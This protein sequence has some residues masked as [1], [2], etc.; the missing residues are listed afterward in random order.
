MFWAHT[1][2]AIVWF[3]VPATLIVSWLIA[4]LLAPV[5]PDHLPG[6]GPFRLHDYRGL[7]THRFTKFGTVLC[8]AFG[9]WTHIVLDAFTHN[10]TWFALHV[11]LYTRPLGPWRFRDQAWTL[12]RIGSLGCHFGLS[13]LSLFLLFR[14]GRARW[15]ADRASQVPL[16]RP[17]ARSY[18][19]LWGV[20]AAIAL[21]LIALGQRGLR[22]SGSMSILV[23][24]VSGSLF[25]GLCL[26]AV[27]VRGSRRRW[28]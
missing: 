15:M 21:P 5:V 7:A 28:G 23:M 1:L 2:P 12:Y 13:L 20:T 27:A 6:L 22:D 8:A 3:C 10:Y 4:R 24:R 16:H 19:T 17:T 18:A 14:Y 26:G 11:P 9:A 25:A